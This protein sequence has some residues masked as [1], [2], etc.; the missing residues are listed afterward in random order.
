MIKV[1]AFDLDNTI[2]DEW[3][4]INA[5]CKKQNINI[6]ISKKRFHQLRKC[7]RNIIES[8]LKECDSY[9]LEIK[10]YFFFSYYNN[11]KLD[12]LLDQKI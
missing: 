1:V 6:E 10:R 12:F 5:I 2:Y 9:S 3:M 7:S 11:I 4:Y 8:I